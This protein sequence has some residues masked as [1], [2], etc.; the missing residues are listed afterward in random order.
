MML[1]IILRLGRDQIW[2]LTQKMAA[3]EGPEILGVVA[4]AA[5]PILPTQLAAKL[6]R[7]EQIP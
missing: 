6:R 7:Q 1:P 2:E 4:A 3:R 5:A